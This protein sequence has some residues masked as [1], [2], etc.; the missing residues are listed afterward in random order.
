[1]TRDDQSQNT[2]VIVKKLYILYIYHRHRYMTTRLKPVKLISSTCNH[3]EKQPLTG[4]SHRF[5]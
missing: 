5:N 4:G 1:M 3:G 2:S